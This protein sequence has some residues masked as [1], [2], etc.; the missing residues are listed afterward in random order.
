VYITTGNNYATPT[1]ADFNVCV[2]GK[3]LTDELTTSCLSSD[4][5]V[6]SI[7]A[8]DMKSGAVKWSHRLW[9]Q[10]DW[11]VA[12]LVGFQRARA[13][14]GLYSALD[15]DTGKLL[16]ATQVGPGSAL[17]GMEWGSAKSSD[18]GPAPRRTRRR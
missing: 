3:T 13:E 10:D 7:V 18:A 11:N 17:G 2:N 8:L 4:D 9:T 5:E 15:P 14:V 6:D 1:A 12:C 16:W